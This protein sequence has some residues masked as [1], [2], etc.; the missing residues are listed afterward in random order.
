MTA[1]ESGDAQRLPGSRALYDEAACGLLLTDPDGLIRRANATMCRWVGRE[2]GELEGRL[3]VQDLLTMGG[4]IF[5]QTHWAPLLQIQGSIAE[6]KLEVVHRDGR[7][8]PVVMNAQRRQ[9]PEGSFHEISL[10]VAEDR[11][12]YEREL[13]LARRRAEQLLV[14]E[15]SAQRALSI[16]L[17]ERDRQRAIAED[18][19][20]F[21]EQMIG[22]VSHDL[23]N[24]LAVIHMSAH[25]LGMSEL[26]SNQ[27]RALGR[28]TNSVARANRL[29]VDLL[30]FTQARL[31][32]GLKLTL[33]PVDLHGVVAEC[34]EDLRLAFA[35]RRLEHRTF[36]D[37]TCVASADRLV[38]MI[39]N[40][41]A[42]AFTYG[43]AD[44]PVAVSSRIDADTFSL[45]VHNEGEPIAAELLTKLFEPMTR[46]TAAGA[47]AHSV[48]LGLFIVRE[49]VRAHGGDVSAE[50]T[51][52]GGTTFRATVPRQPPADA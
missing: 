41:V 20:L 13:L 35:T 8:I 24:P 4:R 38:Q 2:R 17:E 21:A 34:V 9:H 51:R 32:Q 48:G 39:G 45:S 36:G 46:G 40:L 33:K 11:N 27:H 50:S 1:G 6:V 10:F 37:G 18:R 43:A 26:S 47:D 5:H 15:Q 30:D 44:R 16:A 49:I 29:I 52:E 31:G 14:A 7:R 23:R 28:L 12:Q 25:L 42:N 19:A 3:K 22:I